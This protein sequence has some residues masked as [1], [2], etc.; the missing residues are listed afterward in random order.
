MPNN[1]RLNHRGLEQDDKILTTLYQPIFANA[2]RLG[3]YTGNCTRVFEIFA[4]KG[5]TVFPHLRPLAVTN[6][7]VGFEKDF[8]KTPI[9]APLLQ[10]L[11]LS[12]FYFP[13]DPY[14]VFSESSWFRIKHLTLQDLRLDNFDDIGTLFSYC[15]NLEH[16]FLN[17]GSFSDPSSWTPRPHLAANLKNLTLLEYTADFLLPFLSAVRAP[18]LTSLHIHTEDE[19]SHRIEDGEKRNQLG[20]RY[21]EV[22]REFLER[23]DDK[24]SL[25][26]FMFYGARDVYYTP[27]F[28]NQ[29]LDERRQS[30]SL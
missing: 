9:R 2:H 23:L 19:C 1:D 29:P 26:T 17:K 11:T 6:N 28:V 10:K 12:S 13:P 25:K 18:R 16:L 4:S 8:R 14:G 3:S 30:F 7:F 5:H 24:S 27:S 15:P 22:L 20:L 21:F